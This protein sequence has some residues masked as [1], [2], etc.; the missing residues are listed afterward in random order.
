MSICRPGSASNDIKRSETLTETLTS[1]ATS[2]GTSKTE[3]RDSKM[4]KLSVSR[5]GQDGDCQ[6]EEFRLWCANC[7]CHVK[8]YPDPVT[9]NTNGLR[10]SKMSVMEENS[11]TGNT[12]IKNIVINIQCDRVVR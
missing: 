9:T 3:S 10:T 11:W 6:T 7:D 8:V 12:D 5:L 4:S 2:S 1:S